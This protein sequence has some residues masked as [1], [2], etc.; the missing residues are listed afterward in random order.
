VY[1][2]IKPERRICFTWDNDERGRP[3]DITSLVTVEFLDC[4]DGV[5]VCVTHRELSSGQAVDMDIGWNS[6]LDSLEEFAG[7]EGHYF[8]REEEDE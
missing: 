4:S 8:R 1:T 6:T 3:T 7:L 2:E 5:E